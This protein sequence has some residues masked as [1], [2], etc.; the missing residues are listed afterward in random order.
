MI[1]AGLTLSQQPNGVTIR[2]PGVVEI[3]DLFK[4]ADTVALVRILSGDAENYDVAIY[5]GTVIQSFKGSTVGETLYFGP[6][7]GERLGWDYIL[8]LLKPTKTL[9]PKTSANFSYG[10]VQYGEVFE[11]GYSSMMTSY[12]CVF[13]GRDTAEQCD[14]AVRVCTDYIVL[15]KSMRTFPP[16]TESTPFGCR[17][18]RKSDFISLLG[19]LATSKNLR[20]SREHRFMR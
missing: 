6:Y 3:T 5:K 17:W 10:T 1:S 7:L 20:S 18:V 13:A 14:Y 15:P 16:V 11:E 2:E 19:S 4:Q 9:L 12:E 8:F